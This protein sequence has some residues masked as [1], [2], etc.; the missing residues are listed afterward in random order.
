MDIIVLLGLN[1]SS[2]DQNAITTIITDSGI[3][4]AT[5]KDD[6]FQFKSRNSN[7]CGTGKV[8]TFTSSFTALRHL[9]IAQ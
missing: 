1:S 3:A 9:T 6:S 8:L 4:N 7:K 5:I 2:S